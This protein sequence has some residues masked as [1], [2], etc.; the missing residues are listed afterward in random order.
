MIHQLGDGDV[1][2]EEDDRRDGELGAERGDEGRVGG[3]GVDVLEVAWDGLEDLNRVRLFLRVVAV[4]GV[5]PGGEGDDDD[6]EGV[7]HDGEEEERTGCGR[8]FVSWCADVKG[9]DVPCRE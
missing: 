9:M 4:P 2:E 6:V 7:A 3:K 5:E 1:L 8:F